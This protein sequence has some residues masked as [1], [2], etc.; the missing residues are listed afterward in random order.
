MEEKEFF[1]LINNCIRFTSDKYT[2][3]IFYYYDT[4]LIRQSKLS[5]IE[6]IEIKLDLTNIDNDKILFEQDIKNKYFWFWIAQHKIY[7]KFKMKYRNNTLHIN[8]IIK[9][10]LNNHANL[11]EYKTFAMGNI[12]DTRLFDNTNLK[13]YTPSFK[14]RSNSQLLNNYTNLK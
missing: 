3:I 1:D 13:E 9:G 14:S 8:K 7:S 5:K 6:N 12:I 4:K 11:K 2:N 10:M